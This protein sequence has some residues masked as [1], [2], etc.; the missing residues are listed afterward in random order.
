MGNNRKSLFFPWVPFFGPNIPIFQYSILPLFR[1]FVFQ[2]SLFYS[3][4]ISLEM[5]IRWTS[6][7]PS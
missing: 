1:V 3:F 5:T 2:Y 6:E 7:V 4:N